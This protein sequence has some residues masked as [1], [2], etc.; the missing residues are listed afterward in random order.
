[1]DN[2]DS[3]RTVRYFVLDGLADWE[4]SF[5]TPAL[6]QDTRRRAVLGERTRTPAS[7]QPAAPQRL[8]EKEIVGSTSDETGGG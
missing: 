4:A 6:P 2:L 1:M 3:T 7:P 5:L 8:G